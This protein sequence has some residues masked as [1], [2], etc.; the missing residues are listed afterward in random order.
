MAKYEVLAGFASSLG[1]FAFL[2]I[3]WRIFATQNT[4]SLTTAS[5]F[6]NLI[7]QIFLFI[8]AYKN[9][10]KGLMYP[11]ILYVAGIIYILYVKII[12]NKEYL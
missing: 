8:Y 4:I 10:L 12:K 3:V 11:I 9:H 7:A 2:T 1:L 6:S 5:L